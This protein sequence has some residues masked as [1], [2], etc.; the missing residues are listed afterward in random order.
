MVP[1]KEASFLLLLAPSLT[2]AAN[3]SYCGRSFGDAKRNCNAPCV[4]IGIDAANCPAGQYCFGP[5]LPCTPAPDGG[6]AGGV[7]EGVEVLPDRRPGRGGNPNANDEEG[8]DPFAAAL[9]TMAGGGDVD[10]AANEVVGD[11]EEP[12]QFA[13][14]SSETDGA[15]TAT[16]SP[17]NPNSASPTAGP[18]RE[19]A[20]PTAAPTAEAYRL[21]QERRG[22]YNPANH[23]CGT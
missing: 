17:A 7:A 1:F 11:E 22:S 8:G 2:E 3:K 20:A 18:S 4:T 5:D 9:M 19:T 21:A 6:E 23:Y 14:L 12:M 10:P 16:E 15:D 13:L